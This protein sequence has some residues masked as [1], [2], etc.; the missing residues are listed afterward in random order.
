MRRFFLP[1]LL[2]ITVDSIAQKKLTLEEAIATALSNNF[3]IQLSRNESIE[4]A[5]NYGY[6]NA[7]IPG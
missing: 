1:I 5:L 6:R 2:L 3:D 4:A 7:F